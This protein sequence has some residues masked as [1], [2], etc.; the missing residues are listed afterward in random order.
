VANL[1][2]SQ[3]LLPGSDHGAVRAQKDE[4]EMAA[5]EAYVPARPYRPGDCIGG[6]YV[7]DR[8]IGAGGMCTVWVA[9]HAG[10]DRRV[11]LKFARPELPPQEAGRLLREAQATARLE[12]PSIVKVFDYGETEAGNPFIVMELLEGSTFADCLE[13]SGPLSPVTACCLILPVIEALALSHDNGIVHRDLKPS[14][15][16]LAREWGRI[17][18]KLLDFGI[19]K[20]NVGDP[21]P[22]LTMDGAVLGSPSYMAPEQARG[23]NDVDHRADV[24]AVCMVLYEAVVGETPI[25]GDNYNA[26]LRSIVEDEITPMFE[27]GHGEAA[28]W[29]VL[30]RGLVKNRDRRFQSVRDLGVALSRFLL[31]RGV[32]ED[33]SGAPLASKW[34]AGTS[35]E[36]TGSPN[37]T[38]FPLVRAGRATRVSG[39]AF[40]GPPRPARRRWSASGLSVLLA[41]LV[42]GVVAVALPEEVVESLTGARAIAEKVRQSV[43][44]MA[45]PLTTAGATDRA[46]SETV[47][48]EAVTVN[49][50]ATAGAVSPVVAPALAPPLATAVGAAKAKSSAPRR[51]R[52]TEPDERA[53]AAPTANH[54]SEGVQVTPAPATAEDRL[55]ALGLKAPYR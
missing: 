10:L 37:S 8:I 7:L 19:A 22:S 53:A 46:S 40:A 4:T 2:V 27:R 43:A 6:K 55:R 52:G 48:S 23:Q 34:N 5:A 51:R 1:R 17:Q 49:A 39:F 28:L 44:H 13:R 26:L 3:K 24:W 20:L 14:N 12:H 18:P 38:P 42:A 16:F 41:A 47:R 9:T 11:A 35:P 32:T 45:F 33:V 15:I 30:S 36:S 50:T 54:E 21:Q 31:D 29:S 25:R